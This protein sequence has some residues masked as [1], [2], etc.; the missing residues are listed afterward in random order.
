MRLT[1]KKLMQ[2]AGELAVLK[3]LHEE[4]IVELTK[5]VEE[6]RAQVAG[7]VLQKAECGQDEGDCCKNGSVPLDALALCTD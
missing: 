4:E 1:T 2:T 3:I 6:L 7:M 5:E